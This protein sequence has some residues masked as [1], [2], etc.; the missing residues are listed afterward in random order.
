MDHTISNFELIDHAKKLKLPL[1]GV[2]SKDKLPEKCFVGSYI[3][4]LENS[5]GG[6][7]HWTYLRIFGDKKVVYFDSFGLPPPQEIV[8]FVKHF[9]F[10][11][12]QI[13]DLYATTCGY[14]C[15]ACDH[16]LETTKGPVY[17]VYD[18]FLNM[19]KGDTKE[20][21]KILSNYL[22]ACKIYI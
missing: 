13:Q 3:I 6:G 11:S 18:D 15:L 17:D 22:K 4:N 12:R 21:D 10:N 20:N 19:F 8:R 9:A 2:F 7:T 1:I 16:Y 5:S 14:Y